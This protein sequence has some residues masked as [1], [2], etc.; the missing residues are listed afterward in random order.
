VVAVEQ[1]LT[2]ERAASW[3]GKGA[4]IVFIVRKGNAP[5]CSV[6]A[7]AILRN[8]GKLEALPG[9]VDALLAKLNYSDSPDS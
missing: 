1:S 2:P 6:N 8:T 7:H 3:R 5:Q 9:R 4:R